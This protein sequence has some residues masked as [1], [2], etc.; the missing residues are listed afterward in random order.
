[1]SSRLVVPLVLLASCLGCAASVGAGGGRGGAAVEAR[2]DVARGGGRAD[3]RACM[4]DRASG[5][6]RTC[7]HFS[8]GRCA[9]FGDRCEKEPRA[10]AREQGAQPA[11]PA[12]EGAP[13]PP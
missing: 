7:L 4:Y 13:P 8:F 10:P 11:S 6:L 5:Q 1:M 2:G 3:E 12:P 9:L